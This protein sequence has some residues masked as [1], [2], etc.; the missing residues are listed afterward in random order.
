MASLH[1][2]SLNVQKSAPD[3]L[4]RQGCLPLFS[5]LFYGFST[6]F[7]QGIG[8]PLDVYKS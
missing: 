6:Q 3:R 1:W 2:N 8:P 4:R 7:E 5:P